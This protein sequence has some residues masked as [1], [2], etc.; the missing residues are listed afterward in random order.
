MS[1]LLL[2][3]LLASA[4]L[5]AQ[6]PTSP[7]Q[8]KAPPSTANDDKWLAQVSALQ[9]RA[10]QILKNEL[11]RNLRPACDGPNL[12]N[13]EIGKCIN[14]DAD[15]TE[16][17]YRAF[18]QAL[19]NSLAIQPPDVDLRFPIPSKN[20][21]AGEIA[22]RSYVDKTCEA[23]GDISYGGSGV[24]TDMTICQQDLTRQHMRDL[25]KIFLEF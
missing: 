7:G 1:R 11:S 24:P 16:R 6:T 10:R 18:I 13:A 19:K 25:S 4:P 2:I 22:W 8:H 12:S 23:L 21:A 5:L 17:N 15:R 3:L 9:N 20:F 14:A